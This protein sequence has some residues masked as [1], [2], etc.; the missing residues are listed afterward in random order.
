M[1]RFFVDKINLGIESVS[2]LSLIQ[3]EAL[4]NQ[5]IAMGATAKNVSD[6]G[7]EKLPRSSE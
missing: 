3:R 5:L 1:C 7:S 2:G 6:R 4:L